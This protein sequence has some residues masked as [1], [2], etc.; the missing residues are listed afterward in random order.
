MS[1]VHDLIKDLS[2]AQ[3]RAIGLIK[4]SL[5]CFNSADGTGLFSGV[6]R[7]AV[8]AGRVEICA[9]Q[10]RDL[11]QF[12]ALLL[13]RMQWPVPPKGRD[14]AIVEALSAPQPREVLRVLATETASVITLARM[15]HD[16][17]KS[18]RRAERVRIDAASGEI[19]DDTLEGIL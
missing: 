4:L 8:L 11:T 15:L 14:D 17:D 10:A 2:H 5:D 13:R 19:I 3:Q 6:E 1:K 7:Y 18:A 12:W 16:Q 9:A